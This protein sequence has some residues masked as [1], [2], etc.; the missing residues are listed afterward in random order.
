MATTSPS[1]RRSP[2]LG[3]GQ[4]SLPSSSRRPRNNVARKINMSTSNK[5][6]TPQTKLSP[7]REESIPFLAI[8]TPPNQHKDKPSP[9]KSTKR[10][11]SSRTK[12]KQKTANEALGNPQIISRRRRRAAVTPRTR[13]KSIANLLSSSPSNNNSTTART[14]RGTSSTPYL[15]PGKRSAAEAILHKVSKAKSNGNNNDNTTTALHSSPKKKR[16]KVIRKAASDANEKV[17]DI[18]QMDEFDDLNNISPSNLVPYNKPKIS[19]KTTGGQEVKAGRKSKGMSELVVGDTSSVVQQQQ[20]DIVTVDTFIT[21]GKVEE[22]W[23]KNFKKWNSSNNNGEGENDSSSPIPKRWE[24][25]QRAQYRLL[26]QNKKTQMTKDRMKLL[27][28]SGFVWDVQQKG[29]RKDDTKQVVSNDTVTGGKATHKTEGASTSTKED[30]SSKDDSPS[31]RQS[32]RKSPPTQFYHNLEKDKGDDDKSALSKSPSTKKSTVNTASTTAA[33]NKKSSPSKSP[34]KRSLSNTNNSLASLSTENK[35]ENNQQQKKKKKRRGRHST[36]SLFSLEGSSNDTVPVGEDYV[37]K[38]STSFSHS[39]LK[40]ELSKK[41]KR[42]PRK[43]KDTKGGTNEAAKKEEEKTSDNSDVLAATKKANDTDKQSS[44]K[45]KT[46]LSPAESPL[47]VTKLLPTLDKGASSS[48]AAKVSKDTAD[49]EEPEEPEES[50]CVTKLLLSCLSEDSADKGIQSNSQ[51]IKETTEKVATGS[52]RDSSPSRKSPRKSPPT[53]FYHNLE[54]DS[55]DNNNKTL[56]EKPNNEKKKSSPQSPKKVTVSASASKWVDS[57]VISTPE[58]AKLEAARAANTKDIPELGP[59]WEVNVVPRKPGSSKRVDKYY[60]SPTGQRFNS[61]KR[62]KAHA[63]EESDKAVS[64]EKTSAVQ[65]PPSNEQ[66]EQ[67]EVSAKSQQQSSPWTCDVCQDATFDDY[68]EAVAHEKECAIASNNSQVVESSNKEKETT[69]SADNSTVEEETGKSLQSNDALPPAAKVNLPE[70]P[71]A[72]QKER[73]SVGSDG[74]QGGSWTC[75]VCKTATFDDYDEAVAH[76]EKCAIEQRENRSQKN[77]KVA[78][79]QSRCKKRKSSLQSLGYPENEVAVPPTDDLVDNTHTKPSSSTPNDKES[80]TDLVPITAT[81][82]G[83][84]LAIVQ[85]RNAADES[86]LPLFSPLSL[87][88]P[89]THADNRVGDSQLQMV[90]AEKQYEEKMAEFG[91]LE[92]EARMVTQRMREIEQKI[93]GFGSNKVSNDLINMEEGYESVSHKRYQSKSKSSRRSI[94]HN[95]SSHHYSSEEEQ[96]DDRHYTPRKRRHT[97]MMSTNDIES[98]MYSGRKSRRR[99]DTYES[100]RSMSRRRGGSSRNR[101][102]FDDY[103][104]DSEIQEERTPKRR[105]RSVEHFPSPERYNSNRR[106][107][108]KRKRSKVSKLPA[109]ADDVGPRKKKSRP[110]QKTQSQHLFDGIRKENSRRKPELYRGDEYSDEETEMLHST[111]P[112]VKSHTQSNVSHP[113]PAVEDNDVDKKGGAD[114]ASGGENSSD[115]ESWDFEAGNMILPPPPM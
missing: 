68:D 25:E 115:E 19:T 11:N 109:F 28:N 57:P 43:K 27:E 63:Q 77:D 58:R 60:L 10:R 91:R 76:E 8:N 22:R 36:S 49:K 2:R 106:S 14:G 4:Q 3:G 55:G 18:C 9:T 52:K 32:P 6:K 13:G 78:V 86:S 48:L 53:Q 62:A 73:P 26:Q 97:H 20:G 51:S 64:E 111:K 113:Q 98:R 46:G 70:Q 83:N 110:K 30:G 47:R 71:T 89:L 95:W 80:S 69:I 87:T 105:H 7:E 102:S 100:Q 1:T 21:K 59:G 44:G 39:E 41:K 114:E 65:D 104:D 15:T 33:T 96:Y 72:P 103:D 107:S 85:H 108:G 5:N 34:S 66:K 29:E 35:S 45:K 40:H 82:V 54:K 79:H 67:V 50:V 16:R 61:M 99:S 101:P 17:R 24:K 75:D 42:K 74:R 81:H 37:K 31:K 94:T 56:P 92:L 38:E 84:E 90:I 93:K 112:Q 88:S 23:F 12:P